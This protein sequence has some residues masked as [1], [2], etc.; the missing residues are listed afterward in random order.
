MRFL[1]RTWV[2]LL[3]PQGGRNSEDKWRRLSAVPHE[4]NPHVDH[5]FTAGTLFIFTA[6]GTQ[7][8]KL[9]TFLENERE[10]PVLLSQ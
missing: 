5:M 7:S 1:L 8:V 4:S 10:L 3:L 6:L 9:K 2:G